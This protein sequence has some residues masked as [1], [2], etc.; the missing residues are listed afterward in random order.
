MIPLIF[1]LAMHVVAVKVFKKTTPNGKVTVYLGKR[2]FVDRLDGLCDPVDGVLVVDND[3]LKDRRIF[4]QVTTTF[5]YG[6]EEDEVM[7]L[8]FSKDMILCKE[9]VV[10]PPLGKKSSVSNEL[11]P[12]QDRLLKKLGEA[13]AFP[14]TFHLPDLAPPSVTLQPGEQD[15]GRPLGVEYEMKAFVAENDQDPGH[16]RSTVSLRIRKV[17]YAAL[18]RGQKQPSVLVSKGFTFSSGKINLEVTLD[19]DIYYH[20]EELAAKVLVTNTS[21]KAVRNVKVMVIQHC[22]VT[23]VNAHFTR[24]VAHLESREGCPITPGASLT[25]TFQLRPWAQNNRDK[26]GIALDGHLKDEDV[27]LAS[28]TMVVGNP[29]DAL[30]FVVSYSLRVK[31]NLGTLGGELQADLPFKLVHPGP[32]AP[33]DIK[34]IGGKMGSNNRTKYEKQCYAKDADEEDNIIFEDFAKLRMSMSELDN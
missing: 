34:E 8:K 26:R 32:D 20:G 25:K 30:G 12:I 11:S 28:T 14:F 22:E 1:L 18:E 24:T 31:L 3:Y 16:R 33:E 6:R 13:N 15:M 5:R 29:N 2:D 21:K 7:G 4:G 19:R 10:P 23:M 27:N 9:Q 17:Q